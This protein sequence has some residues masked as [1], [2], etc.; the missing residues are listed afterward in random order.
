MKVIKSAVLGCAFLIAASVTAEDHVSIASQRTAQLLELLQKTPRLPLERTE[1]GI[2][3]PRTDWAVEMVSSV[4]VDRKG[5]V[6][7]L[8]R[9]DKA[10]PVIALSPDGKV[11]RSWG[12]GLYKIP[13][14]IRIDPAGNVWTVDAA[15]SIVLKFTPEGR[16]LLEILVGEQSAGHPSAFNGTTDIAFAPNGQLL[17]SD[18]YGN[19]RILRYSAEGKRLGEW[20]RPG[21]GLGEFHL[22]HGIAIDEKGIVYVADRENGR[23]QRFDLN[24]RPLGEWS[25]LGRTFSLTVQGNALWIGTQPHDQPNTSPGWLMKVDRESGKILGYVDSTGQHSIHATPGAEL[26]NGSRPDRVVWYRSVRR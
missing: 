14:S 2:Q 13:H 11:L 24:G 12:K 18:G 10:D 17:I 9:G 15:S 4:A 21:T 8:Q 23:V 20:G 25:H 5:I 26:L 22:P 19:A 6:Y 16:K 3:A 7:V 1:L